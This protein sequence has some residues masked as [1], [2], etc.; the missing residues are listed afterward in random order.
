MP[1]EQNKMEFNENQLKAI[2][3]IKGPVLV[4]AGPGSG[5]TFTLVNRIYNMVK[6]GISTE[7]ILTITFTRKAAN[8]MKDRYLNLVNNNKN[9]TIPTF[10]TFHSIFY[11]ILRED[12]GYSSKSLI[13]KD[14][15]RKFLLSVI[16]KDNTLNI[17]KDLIDN[18]IDDF[19]KENIL[20]EKGDKFTPKSL[21]RNKYIKIRKNYE[22]VLYNNKKLNFHGMIENC[23]KL[24]NKDKEVLKKY[25]NKYKYIL[26]DEFQDINN[27]QYKILKLICKSKNIFVVG[28]DDQSIYKFRGSNP[29]IIRD[30]K[31][32]YKN[33][34]LIILNEN[35]RC[36]NNIV[37]FSKKIIDK[38]KDRI[39]K[40]LLSNKKDGRLEI[41]AFDDC[42]KENE[43]IIRLIR[44]YTKNGVAPNDIA[45]LY[46][47]NILSMALT[48]ELKKNN[49]KFNIKDGNN[50]FLN[51]F[52][53]NDII[54]YLKLSLGENDLI[55]SMNIINKPNRYISRDSISHIEFNIK[56]IKEY[57]KKIDFV[58]KNIIK[59]ENDLKTIKKLITP[60][61]IRY[62]RYDIGYEKYLIDYCKK[63]GVDYN[64]IKELID[65]LEEISIKYT[66]IRSFIE[67]LDS[68]NENLK[69]DNSNKDSISLMTFHL[70]KGLEYKVVIIIDANDGF[71]PH[72]KSIENDLETE[73]RLFY[74]A[75][76]RSKLFLHIFFTLNR[77]GK[78][79]K[80]S[81]FIRE[82]LGG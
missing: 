70:S 48:Y 57:Y 26:V 50:Y 36:P 8:E 73:R 78:Q 23:Y 1:L 31:K 60:L 52:A 37:K 11:M 72:R 61:A 58:Y 43:Y 2:N 76:T 63:N 42:I 19:N 68:F 16:E 18:I 79:F 30:F 44:F 64:E 62:I 34:K 4:L 55:T 66:D 67:F 27:E 80:P 13:T 21:T 10:G 82:A 45:V 33:Y 7:N 12:F 25:Q 81:R 54:S 41:R 71:I 77:Q 15:E 28:D 14:E 40:N 6:S 65:Y 74:V 5:K 46:R 20:K 3:Q 47:T 69:D 29:S 51:N 75:V 32:D 9:D 17:K 56:D 39:K 35:Y 22:E 53:I 24:L 59:L 49:I 38:N